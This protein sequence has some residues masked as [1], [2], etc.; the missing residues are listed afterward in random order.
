MELSGRDQNH[1]LSLAPE[2]VRI[3]CAPKGLL[4][5]QIPMLIKWLAL[6]VLV[7]CAHCVVSQFSLLVSCTFSLKPGVTGLRTPSAA[8]RGY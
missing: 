7:P 8:L 6:L 1:I 5:I 2:A 3:H 4:H